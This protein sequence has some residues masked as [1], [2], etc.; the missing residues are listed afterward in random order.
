MTIS[1]SNFTE[2]LIHE[3]VAKAVEKEHLKEIIVFQR[4]NKMRHQQLLRDEAAAAIA[5]AADVDV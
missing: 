1:L 4:S 5:P 3:A 2:D